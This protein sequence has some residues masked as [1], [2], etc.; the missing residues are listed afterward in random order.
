MNCGI[1]GLK[2][3]DKRS[4]KR[5][6]NLRMYYKNRWFIYPSSLEVIRKHSQRV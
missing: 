3:S 6:D 1:T 5:G 2:A 4:R